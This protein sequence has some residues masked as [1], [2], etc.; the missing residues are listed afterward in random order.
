MILRTPKS[1]VQAARSRI[2]ATHL[3]LGCESTRMRSRLRTLTGTL[4]LAL[5]A[6]LLACA[7]AGAAM[8]GIYRNGLDS[9]AQRKALVKLSG[10]SCERSGAAGALRIGVGKRTDAC[11][12]RT[13]VL[14]RDLEIAATERLL[15]GTPP[16][17]QHKAYVGLEL[18]AGGGAKYQLLA[19]PLQRKV[20]LIKITS[21]G[22]EFLQIAKNQ[23]A[24]L[25][26]NKANALRL[27]AINRGGADKGSAQLLGFVG[28]EQVVE[29]IDAAAG[30]LPG[31]ASAVVV[32]AGKG[33][34]GVIGSV[35][36]VV[37]RVPSPF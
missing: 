21:E 28:G 19:Y 16:A 11:S 5:A 13:P 18:R 36:N 8:V 20:Q 14:G 6:A 24:V 32:G 3:C 12:L 2:F 30:E 29:A 27:R 15:S 9:K 34:N 7:V 23:K 10:A 22:T 1:P 25:G 26:L 31:R 37:L 33:G 17:L 35:D 4:L